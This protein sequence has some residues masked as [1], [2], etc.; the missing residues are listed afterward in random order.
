M[1]QLTITYIPA[2]KLHHLPDNARKLKDKQAIEKLRGLIRSHGFR[3]PLEVWKD[4]SGRWIIIVGNHRFKAGKLEGMKE[5]PCIEYTGT[6]DMA[7]ARAL[8]DNA[9]NEWTA[10]N[11]EL[12][13]YQLEQLDISGINFLQTGIDFTLPVIDVAI[14]QQAQ[15]QDKRQ[16]SNNADKQQ[17]QPQQQ[18]HSIFIL[19]N[20]DEF[21]IWKKFRGTKTDKQCILDIIS[22]VQHD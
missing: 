6:R 7:L 19:L 17:Q 15:Q 21:F 8:S 10:W 2:T 13:D 11:I 4:E 9:S 16:S 12:R 3:S 22:G 1:S 20:R 14:D 5:F 18:N